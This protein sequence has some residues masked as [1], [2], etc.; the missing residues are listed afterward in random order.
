MLNHA[1]APRWGNTQSGRHPL[2]GKEREEEEREG[3]WERTAFGEKNQ[4]TSKWRGEI[5]EDP[6][7][8]EVPPVTSFSP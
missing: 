6:V 8:F 7:D 2:R 5:N 3:D 1:A 4:P